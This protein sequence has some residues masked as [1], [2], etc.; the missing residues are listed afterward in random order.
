MAGILAAPMCAA[1]ELVVNGGF[2]DPVVPFQELNKGWTT[3]YG[4]NATAT[5]C[6]ENLEEE[7]NGGMLVPGWNVDWFD[8]VLDAQGHI[9][10]I[11]GGPGRVEIQR[12]L[13]GEPALGGISAY[14]GDQKAELDSHHRYQPHGKPTVSNNVAIYQT[15]P[16]CPLTPYELNFAW[17]ART[18]DEG[19]STL[20]VVVNDTPLLTVGDFKEGWQEETYKFISS[21]EPGELLGFT[22][23]GEAN[24]L[25][26]F[27]DG[28][29][30]QGPDGTVPGN[31]VR[32]GICGEKP[33]MIELLYDADIDGRDVHDQDA[34][35]VFIENWGPL[36]KVAKI[37]VFDHKRQRTELFSGTVPIGHSFEV[38]GEALGH[39]WIPPK[40]TVEI[41]DPETG[42]MVQSIEFHTSCSQPLFVGDQFGG[43]SVYSFFR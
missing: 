3:F 19:D 10:A 25:G 4:K 12:D 27:V 39:R 32:E 28:I 35:S 24:T 26:A 37:K 11:E 16:T 7:C 1:A 14:E 2:E 43:I 5:T 40:L 29:S 6:E 31:C 13:E 20:L 36:P 38:T 33:A 8:F 15:L 34:D 30:V 9:V 21:A 42:Q 18:E 22:S 41:T 17:K 23:V